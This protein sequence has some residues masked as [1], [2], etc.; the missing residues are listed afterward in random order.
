[1]VVHG[2]TVARIAGTSVDAGGDVTVSATNAARVD[3]RLYASGASAG[4]DLGIT[5]AFNS[6]GWESQNVLFNTVDAILGAP[7]LSGVVGGEVKYAFGAEEGADAVAEI[8]ESP[9]EA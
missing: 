7:I 4:T 9:V 5:L 2:K 6:V 8:T 3:A 1:N